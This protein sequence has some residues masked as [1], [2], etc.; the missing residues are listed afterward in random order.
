MEKNLSEQGSKP[1]TNS[2]HI[3]H[4]WLQHRQPRPGHIDG[5]HV[6]KGAQGF[7]CHILGSIDHPTGTATIEMHQS[8]R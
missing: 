6:L 8:Q 5:R 4:V 7:D 1:T 3:I 2:T